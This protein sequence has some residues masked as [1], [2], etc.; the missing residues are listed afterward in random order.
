MLRFV[1]SAVIRWRGTR[2]PIVRWVR[3]RGEHV[4]LC[5]DRSLD[6]DRYALCSGGWARDIGRLPVHWL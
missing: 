5:G 4:Y 3:F 1:E 6:P 2:S